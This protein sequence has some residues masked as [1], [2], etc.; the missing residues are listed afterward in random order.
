[1]EE[2]MFLGLRL[3]EGICIS[4]FERNFRVRYSKVYGKVTESLARQGLLE[5]CGD[6][7]R[8][9][10]QGMDVSNY[11]MAQFLF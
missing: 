4:D 3:K 5:S 11:V 6:R 10:G 1:M 7:I 2:F 9:T 8:L